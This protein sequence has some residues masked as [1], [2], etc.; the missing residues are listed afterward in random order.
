MAYEGIVVS[1]ESGSESVC[2]CVCV[3]VWKRSMACWKY[4]PYYWPAKGKNQERM[5]SR[6]VLLFTW[7][8]T[9]RKNKDC[10]HIG[11]FQEAMK[12]HTVSHF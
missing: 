2:V 7:R 5:G 8:W 6:W 12:N 3:C 4:C 10:L 1:G 11:A 9:A